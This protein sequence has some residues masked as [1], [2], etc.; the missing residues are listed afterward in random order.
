MRK[1]LN[2]EHARQS[3]KLNQTDVV[4]CVMLTDGRAGL[5]DV[6]GSNI[7]EGYGYLGRK[8]GDSSESD[9]IGRGVITLSYLVDSKGSC[10]SFAEV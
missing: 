8:V 10:P 1:C 7:Y 3:G 9:G 4:A 2:C 6:S 5:G